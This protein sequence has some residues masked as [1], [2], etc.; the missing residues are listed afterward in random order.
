MRYNMTILGWLHMQGL[1]KTDWLIACTYA[2]SCTTCWILSWHVRKQLTFNLLLIS[3][4]SEKLLQNA[5]ACLSCI[6]CCSAEITRYTCMQ[7]T[8]DLRG[9]CTAISF[10]TLVDGQK[11][12]WWIV[13]SLGLPHQKKQVFHVSHFMENFFLLRFEEELWAYL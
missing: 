1:L 10:L 11:C 13:G 6:A 4:I 2:M 7:V 8:F 9:G 12:P 5:G 3:D